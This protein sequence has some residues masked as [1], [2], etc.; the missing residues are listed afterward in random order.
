M[1]GLLNSIQSLYYIAMTEALLIKI[2]AFLLQL[3]ALA[4]IGD[5][6]QKKRK[7]LR[8]KLS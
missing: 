3:L 8:L 4:F 5:N 7:K 6:K 1:L 2:E